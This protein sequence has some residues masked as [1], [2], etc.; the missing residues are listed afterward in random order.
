MKSDVKYSLILI[1]LTKLEGEMTTYGYALISTR[2]QTLA[3]QNAALRATGCSKV[4]SE[5]TSGAKTDRAELGKLLKR[6]E[7]GDVLVVTSLDRLAGSTGDLLNLLHTIAKAGAG[8]K[9]LA[10]PWCDTTVPHGELRVTMLA[11]LATFE[12]HLIKARA[13]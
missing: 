13:A 7:K 3:A 11:G 5:K 6:L 10:D 4:Y 9:S 8:V 1:L 12:R 2:C